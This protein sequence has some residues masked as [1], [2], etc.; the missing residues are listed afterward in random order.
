MCFRCVYG[1]PSRAI[2]AE[3][4]GFVLN[5]QGF[6]IRR[7]DA[8]GVTERRK[9]KGVAWIGVNRYLNG[10]EKSITSEDFRTASHE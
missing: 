8:V 2:E 9:V 7:F 10:I 6:D 5:K 1:C 4:F 3:H